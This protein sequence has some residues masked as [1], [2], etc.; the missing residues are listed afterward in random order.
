MKMLMKLALLAGL[1]AILGATSARAGYGSLAEA[2]AAAREQN[3]PLLIDFYT[4]W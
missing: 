1:F 3:K 4:E 2:Q